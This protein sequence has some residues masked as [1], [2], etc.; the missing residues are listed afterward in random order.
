M[1]LPHMHFQSSKQCSGRI[2]N[3]RRYS[4]WFLDEG[5]DEFHAAGA[6]FFAGFE[7]VVESQ[8]GECF[9]LGAVSA[10]I[11][12][13]A[14]TCC[15]EDHQFYTLKYN[16]TKLFRNSFLAVLYILHNNPSEVEG[17]IGEAG[18]GGFI[19]GGRKDGQGAVV[20]VFIEV[21]DVVGELEPDAIAIEEPADFGGEVA[22]HEVSVGQDG[23]TAFIEAN[24]EDF[25]GGG[26]GTITTEAEAAGLGAVD[27]QE[28][29]V[30]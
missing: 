30:D 27:S 17:T 21:L 4:G 13:A 16:F 29:L 6:S 19:S 10:G 25:V 1:G 5:G 23:G 24:A 22:G 20:E 2:R 26:R 12:A 15:L 9:K 14:E 28:A 11:E 3:S 18:Q 8:G 7:E